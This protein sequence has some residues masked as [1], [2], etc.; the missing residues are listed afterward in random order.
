MRTKI[1]VAVVIMLVCII[2]ICWATVGTTRITGVAGAT[3]DIKSYLAGDL[4]ESQVPLV[5]ANT[6]WS[7]GAGA[8]QANVTY[9]DTITLA[10][11]NSTTLDLYASG[12]LLDIHNRALTMTALKVLYL[13]NNSTDATL[14]V[15]GGASNDIGILAATND[16]LAIPP[17]G[18]FVYTNP[19]SAGLVITTNK[20]LKL[21]HNGTGS[22]AM[23]IDVVAMGND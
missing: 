3:I 8:N 15:F 13:K 23:T 18:T 1:T 10:D 22:S 21:T 20:N 11:A 19:A 17:G 16:I 6:S 12:T 9:A 14:N 4:S 5:V 2:G 7:Y